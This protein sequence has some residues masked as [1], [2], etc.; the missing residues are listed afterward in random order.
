MPGSTNLSTYAKVT[1][2]Y[3]VSVESWAEQVSP[4]HFKCKICVPV[5]VL[6]FLKGKG[7]LTQHSESEKHRKQSTASSNNNSKQ[8]SVVDIL[9]T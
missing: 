7:A 2:K 9:N 1:D 5:K 6:S 8:P 4:G 3:G